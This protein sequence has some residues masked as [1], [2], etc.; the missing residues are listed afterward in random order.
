MIDAIPFDLLEQAALV[1]PAR[2]KSRR[3]GSDRQSRTTRN[4]FFVGAI[5][6]LTGDDG[7]PYECEVTHQTPD[8]T[9][10]C[11]PLKENSQ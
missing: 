7:E 2:K 9:W 5:V 4:A 1:Q 6:L 8:G 10:W 11:Q 3:S